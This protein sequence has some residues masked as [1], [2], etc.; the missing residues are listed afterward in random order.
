MSEE[1]IHEL[2]QLR[3]QMAAIQARLADLSTPEEIEQML[4][5]KRQREAAL[6]ASLEGDGIVVQGDN[7]IA[8]A[9]RAAHL[10]D[11]QGILTTGDG[12]I[13]IIADQVAA[14]FWRQFRGQRPDLQQATSQ[15]LAYLVRQYRYLAFKGMGVSDRVPLR[16]PLMEMYVP[17][18]A[19]IEMPEGET[20]G[21]QLRLAGRAL[22]AEEMAAAGNRFSQPQPLV[23]LLQHNAGLIILGDPGAG[24]TTFL[25]YLALRLAAGEGDALGVG[26]RLPV[27]LPLSAYAE[28]LARRDVPLHRFMADYYE[29]L[30]V[31]LPLGP[32]LDEALARGGVLL[33]LDGLDE[34]KEA[35]RRQVVMSRLEQFFT[36]QSARGNKFL[37]TSRIVGYKEV[38]PSTDGL[39]E[40]TLVDFEDEEIEQFV[41]KWTQA[42]ERQAQGEANPVAVQAAQ[43]EQ[44]ELLRSIRHNAGVRRLAANPLLLT[45]L[46]LMKRQGILL[47][48]RR[49][50]L[51]QKYVETLLKQ[52][53]L[54]RGL[55]RPSDRELDVVETVRTLAPLALWMH[56]TSPGVGLVKREALRRELERLYE[57]RGFS[58][59][60]GMA[61]QLLSDA[62]EH[63]GLLLER[64]AGMYGFIHLTFQEYLAAVALGQKGQQEMTP[65]VEAL[66]K[67]V[68]DDN[69]HEVTLLTIGYL[70]L[71]QQ[72]DEA[73]TSVLTE[74]MA[75]APGEP[76]EAVILAGEAVADVGDG[77][78]TPA[79]KSQVIEQLLSTMQA[80]D[81][82]KPRRR[83]QAGAVLAH[84]GDPRREVMDVDVMPFCLIPGGDF[85]M[86]N[87]KD[88]VAPIH[89]QTCL[90]YDYW[91]AQYPVTYSQYQVFM[92][93]GGYANPAY[94]AEAIAAE[95]WQEGKVDAWLEKGKTKPSSEGEKNQPV[96][97][98]TWYEALALARW[99]DERWQGR[100]WLPPGLHV[101]LPT[102]AEWEKAG[103]GGLLVPSQ[104]I[105][106]SVVNGRLRQFSQN[107]QPTSLIENPLAQRAFPW[108][109]DEEANR[110]NIKTSGIEA[111]SSVGCFPQGASPYGCEEM[112]GNVWEWCRSRYA[113]YPYQADYRRERWARGR[114]DRTVLRGGVYYDDANAS[115]V[116]ARY[117]YV[118]G[119]DLWYL[120]VRFVLSP[121]SSPSGL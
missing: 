105:V 98:L 27:L 43:Q 12:N 62:R 29:Q 33:M 55:G 31:E 109:D 46:A 50:E 18:K 28:A 88:K 64:G 115:R 57:Q 47:P 90:S 41:G 7:N 37:L 99:L 53:N 121:F 8:L 21:H 91:L 68:G 103:R 104:A 51:Y 118:P 61:R 100:G 16:L 5:P 2:T 35:S 113:G 19:R 114:G 76:G 22:S 36:F 59:S 1:R 117:G 89:R 85:W 101:S 23:E 54:A 72:R 71:I 95:V 82:V 83:A 30:G 17:L 107:L 40:C 120:G 111:I 3:Q 24:K 58:D 20:W 119:N 13:I 92:D 102:E 110:A 77:G 60:A 75:L 26:P 48:E 52:W 38:R 49:V 45:I 96:R 66:A 69:W 9:Q 108:G 70:G 74:L 32:M 81:R 34:V 6:V 80:V 106:H 25:K 65:V 86:G 78:V 56:E 4:Q 94:W 15:Y 63:A 87:V 79:G 97:G 73:A 42:I 67:H 116:G 93:E 11:N 14:D 84:V 44:E 10:R 112:S 39:A